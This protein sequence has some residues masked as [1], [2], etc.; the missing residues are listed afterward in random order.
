MK[1]L[2]SDLKKN[3]IWFDSNVIQ[4]S[5]TETENVQWTFLKLWSA[6][7]PI[8]DF[9]IWPI[10]SVSHTKYRKLIF[11]TRIDADNNET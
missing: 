6:N 5:F 4:T 11:Y 8:M 3:P 10:I 2:R 1:L 7:I 9:S